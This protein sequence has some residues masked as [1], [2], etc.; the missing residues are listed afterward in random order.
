MIKSDLVN[1]LCD[2]E[3]IIAQIVD[4]SGGLYKSLNIGM[5][6]VNVFD[7]I[8]AK[9]NDDGILELLSII[10]EGVPHKKLYYFDD[11]TSWAKLCVAAGKFTDK[12]VLQGLT[13]PRGT[14]PGIVAIAYE[15]DFDPTIE[16]DG[17]IREMSEE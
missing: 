14:D 11:M 15:S 16:F 17:L 7:I 4:E 3:L 8:K 1:I 12:C 9:Q 5:G 2:N 10:E 6:E 13:K